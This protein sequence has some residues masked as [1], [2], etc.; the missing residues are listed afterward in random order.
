LGENGENSVK[1]LRNSG[2]YTFC[3][4]DEVRPAPV[5]GGGREGERVNVTV[6]GFGENKPGITPVSLLERYPGPGPRKG[7]KGVKSG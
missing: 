3:Q 7:E 5:R 4:K 2:I 1:P 6:G